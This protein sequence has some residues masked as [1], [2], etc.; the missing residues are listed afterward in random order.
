MEYYKLEYY[1]VID[2]VALQLDNRFKQEGLLV[3][4]Q[5]EK[6]LLLGEVT[7]ACREY[8]EISQPALHT[9]LSMLRQQFKYKTTEE[10]AG[11]LRSAVP[12]VRLLFNQVETLLR[13]LL[14]VPTTS[15]EAERSFSSLRRLKTWLRCSMSQK[16]TN[17][18]AVCHV[19]QKYIDCIDIFK[20][21]N[22]F[23]G[24]NE[25]RQSLFGKF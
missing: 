22:K 25:R 7:Y 4:E 21:V 18:V 19:H 10:A 13:I 9:Q 8:P 23:V 6:C 2:T 17:A 5:L 24:N 16:H 12:E 15:C 1:K 3:Y 11:M 14:V 20:L